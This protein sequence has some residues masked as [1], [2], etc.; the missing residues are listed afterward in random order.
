MKEKKPVLLDLKV[1]FIRKNNPSVP[2]IS[3][4]IY[5]DGDWWLTRLVFEDKP[6]YEAQ[7]DNL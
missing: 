1:S 6:G 2:P 3:T 5:I 4:L 7:Y